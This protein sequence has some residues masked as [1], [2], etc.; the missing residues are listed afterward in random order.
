[1]ASRNDLLKGK[2]RAKLANQQLAIGNRK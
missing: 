2:L 1:L